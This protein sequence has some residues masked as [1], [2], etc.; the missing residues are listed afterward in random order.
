MPF[1]LGMMPNL[2]SPPWSFFHIMALMRSPTIGLSSPIRLRSAKSIARQCSHLLAAPRYDRPE[3]MPPTVAIL[4][5]AEISVCHLSEH[6]APPSGLHLVTGDR[7]L[8]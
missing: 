1:A 5:F 8:P 4:V 7:S 3:P 2:S 6:L